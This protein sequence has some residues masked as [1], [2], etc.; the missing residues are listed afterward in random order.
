M[1]VSASGLV[2]SSIFAISS[3]NGALF[4][5]LDSSDELNGVISKNGRYITLPDFKLD[6]YEAE[7]F[8]QSKYDTNLATIN[9]VSEEEELVELVSSINQVENDIGE[10]FNFGNLWIGANDVNEESKWLW[11][12]GNDISYSD[13]CDNEP[14]EDPSGV[15]DCG[16]IYLG[17]SGIGCWASGGC[18]DKEQVFA[19][20]YNS[21][22]QEP[23]NKI[24]IKMDCISK[25]STINCNNENENIHCIDQ[26]KWG[27]RECENGYW[28]ESNSHPCVSCNLISNCNKCGDFAGC[29]ECKNGYKK[30]WH[31]NCG[32][33]ISVCV[34]N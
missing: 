33:G 9:S 12:N 16:S 18:D 6:W 15:Q 17:R 24:D 23:D 28:K 29:I 3:V 31:N 8:C 34:P 5:L 21:N 13:W 25:C 26:R 27:C 11:S 7:E 20:D 2:F 30:M 19:C 32:V 22:K 1:F 4:Q 10:R 14:D